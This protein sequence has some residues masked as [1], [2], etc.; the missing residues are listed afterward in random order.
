MKV[1]ALIPDALIDE[2]KKLS[3]GK[4]IT[5]SLVIALREWI[6]LQKIKT[7]NQKVRKSPLKFSPGFTGKSVRALNRKR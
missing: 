1:T 2:V 4:N 5:D 7:V 3:K 6:A